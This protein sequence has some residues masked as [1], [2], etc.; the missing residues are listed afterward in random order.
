MM[1]Q[2][3]ERKFMLGRFPEQEIREGYL[4][5]IS[6]KEID[7]TYLAL[8]K[9]EEIRIRK[10][11]ENGEAEYTHTFKKGNGL[12]REEI[13]YAISEPIYSQ[14]LAQSG[15]TP[16]KKTRT[17][18]VAG[19]LHYDIDEYRPQFDLTVVE[20]EFPDEASAHRFAAPDWFGREVGSEEEYRN[21]KLWRSLQ[22]NPAAG[23]SLS[24]AIG[25]DSQANDSK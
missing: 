5:F 20:V 23:S 13:E 8:S 16:L 1:S 12:S 2:E 19:E 25:G 15:K 4:Q 24:V 7:Q 14:L 21:K 17:T 10:L 6:R 3:I 18:V 22:D 9:G 11:S